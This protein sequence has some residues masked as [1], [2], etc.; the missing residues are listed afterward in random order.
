MY[1]NYI[2][3]GQVVNL[4]PAITAAKVRWYINVQE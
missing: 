4:C 2:G 1:R 3:K